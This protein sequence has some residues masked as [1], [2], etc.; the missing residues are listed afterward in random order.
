VTDSVYIDNDMDVYSKE[1]DELF[2]IEAE[3]RKREA[4]FF[5]Y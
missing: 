4:W 1:L 3:D 5:Q 2:E